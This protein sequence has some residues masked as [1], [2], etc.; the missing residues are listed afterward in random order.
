MRREGVDPEEHYMKLVVTAMVRD[1]ADIIRQW[2]D[3]HL[4]QGVDAIIIT[5][6]GSVDGTRE[7]LQQ[8]SD[9]GSIDLRDEPIQRK[10][11]GELVTAMA[12]E[13]SSRYGADWVVNA[14]ADEFLIPV[15][16]SLTLRDV[17]ERLDPALASFTVPVVNL[18]GRIAESGAGIDRLVWRDERTNDQLQQRGVLAQPTPNAVH[19]G[20]PDVTVVQGNHLV[21]IGSN[22]KPPAD[23]ALEVLH[24]P[25]RS[26]TQLKNKV[27]IS[28]RAYAANPV[29]QPSPNHHGMLDYRRYNEGSLFYYYALRMVTDEALDSGPFRLDRSLPD[30]FATID[31]DASEYPAD[32]GY[33]DDAVREADRV[34]EMLFARDT[35]LRTEREDHHREAAANHTEIT[36]ARDRILELERHIRGLEGENARLAAELAAQKQRKIVRAADSV[37]NLARRIRR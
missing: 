37:G 18:V 29:L 36:A 6:N 16:R 17:F 28:G 22:G 33:S 21:S 20:S 34:G 11:Q 10:Q 35:T 4:A 32:V 3:Y 15:D 30:F 13:A 1:E 31:S 9:A 23:L 12:R 14:D 7:I 24:L 8:Y 25:W 19:V 2:I 26:W 27:E 5:D